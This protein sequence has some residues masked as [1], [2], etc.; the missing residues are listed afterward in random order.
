MI[1]APAA[2]EDER[3]DVGVAIVGGGPAGLAAAIRLGQ[4]LGDDPALTEQ[5]GEVP[6]ALLD[7]G[8][9]VGSHQLSGAVVNPAALRD[10]LPGVSL[11]SL[12]SYGEV[13]REA[14]HFLTGSARAVR[15]PTPPPFHNKGNHVFSLSRLARAL[16]EQAEELGVMLLPETDAQQLL[17]GEGAVRGVRTGDKGRLRDGSPGPSFEPGAEL[18]AGAT[19]LADGVQGLLTS[20]AIDHFGLEGENPQV[21]ALGVKEIW[22]VPRALD[23]VIHTLGWPLRAG[24]RYHEFGGSFI[25]PMGQDL[26][27]LGF[28]AGLDSSDASLSVH[29]LLQEL[30]T[31]PLVRRIL[32]AASAS[33]G[34]PR[35]SPRA[36]SGRCPRPCRR[37]VR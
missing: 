1:A 32:G 31:H 34:A 7:K 33:A 9:T 5:L 28:V 22:K 29:D 24:R 8:R 35:R 27:S 25:Y 2:A 18:H 21:Y 10:L 26:V 12:T 36:A 16:A 3:I 13:R 6:I 14:V 30:K 20:A 15:L 11:E 19:V 4:L 23:R 17:V 37:P